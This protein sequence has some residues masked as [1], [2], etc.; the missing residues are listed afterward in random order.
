MMKALDEAHA[1]SDYVAFS[2][3]HG[4]DDYGD[5]DA[6]PKASC[7]IRVDTSV[8]PE[9]SVHLRPRQV[10]FQL[11]YKFFHDTK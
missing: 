8:K 1:S 2:E 10:C 3:D 4:A 7:K 9:N 5:G 6:E 11:F